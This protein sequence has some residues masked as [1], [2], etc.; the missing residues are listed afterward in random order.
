MESPTLLTDALRSWIGREVVYTAP[1]E[2]GRAAIRYF[3]IA[4][5][6]ENP[7]YTDEEYARAAG[8]PSVIA[9]P[10]L[11]CET[12]QYMSRR[13][14]AD[15]YIGH[16]WPLPLEGWRV[17]RGGN[18]Y[19]FHRTVLPHHRITARW[20]LADI[21]ERISARSGAMLIVVS[22]VTYTDQSGDLLA[23][24]RETTIYQPRQD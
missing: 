21:Q 2:L 3:A 19:E 4:I 22:E 16:R 14:D 10:T 24:N 18:E 15:G 20:R 8:H 23:T 12:N 11:V 9:P 7:L 13:P 5:G 17:I 6:D 1:E